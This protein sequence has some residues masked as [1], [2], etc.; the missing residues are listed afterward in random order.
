MDNVD[1]VQ[2]MTQIE[3]KKMMNIWGIE[4]TEHKI[5]HNYRSMPKFRTYLLKEYNNILEER[6]K[7]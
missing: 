3:L 4:G 1:F 6:L 5:K 7:C 2:V